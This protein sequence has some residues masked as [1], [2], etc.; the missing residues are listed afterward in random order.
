M[1]VRKRHS[2]VPEHRW[3]IWRKSPRQTGN[4][5]AMRHPAL[6]DVWTD[7]SGESPQ[8]EQPYWIGCPRLQTEMVHVHSQRRYSGRQHST[9]PQGDDY[10]SYQPT[11]SSEQLKEHHLRSSSLQAGNY[12]HNTFQ[13]DL[14]YSASLLQI[15]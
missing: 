3:A 1:N 7:L 10:V 11:L 13:I 12:V 8:P 14:T 6:N 2:D 5:V 15:S 9:I 4:Q